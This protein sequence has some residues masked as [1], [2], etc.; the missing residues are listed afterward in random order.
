MDKILE[1]LPLIFVYLDDILVSSVCKKSHKRDLET[2]FKRL[3]DASL[4]IRVLW[5]VGVLP[6]TS[7][8]RA[9]GCWTSMWNLSGSSPYVYALP[10]PTNIFSDFL[11]LLPY[12]FTKLFPQTAMCWGYWVHCSV[13]FYNH[14][15]LIFGC[16]LSIF[17]SCFFSSTK[18]EQSTGLGRTRGLHWNCGGLGLVSVTLGPSPRCRSAPSVAKLL[19]TANFRGWGNVTTWGRWSRACP[20]GW[21]MT[22]LREQETWLNTRCNPV[23]RSVLFQLIISRS[24]TLTSKMNT[25]GFDVLLNSGSQCP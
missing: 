21:H 11:Y 4:V 8:Q 14:V 2:V 20:G 17:F 10:S 25:R 13:H 16:Q 9:R 7:A 5:R 3:E 22:S 19:P 1:G 23:V 12:P 24:K 18:F 15:F 6:G